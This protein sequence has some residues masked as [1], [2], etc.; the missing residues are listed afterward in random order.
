MT[1]IERSALV[2]FSPEQMFALVND[3]ESYPEF[4]PGCSGATILARGDDWLDA[5][6][7]LLRMG[8]KQSFSTRNTLQ[9]PATMSM[10]LLDGPFSSM[11]GEWN[12]EMLTESACKVTFWLEFDVRN[13]ILA[14]TLPTLMEQVTSEQVDALCQRARDV[15]S[16]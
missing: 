14:M 8:F 15:Y 13:P 11:E 12:F 7:D 2:P 5:R 1:R 4:M 3:I 9:P 6:L 10:S 16:A